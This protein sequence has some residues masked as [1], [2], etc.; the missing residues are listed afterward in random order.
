MTSLCVPPGAAVAGENP[1]GKS[2]PHGHP[3]ERL[4]VRRGACDAEVHA[5]VE[6]VRA[7][8]LV[9]PVGVGH[10]CKNGALHSWHSYLTENV[11]TVVLRYVVPGRR[12]VLGNCGLFGESGKRC[13]SR[14]RPKFFL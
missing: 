13:V 3:E 7:D 2:E 5:R 10:A 1:S 14:Q 6:R 4:H 12:T 11:W 8:R 9:G